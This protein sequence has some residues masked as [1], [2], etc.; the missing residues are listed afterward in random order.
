MDGVE[1]G[2]DGSEPNLEDDCK[3]QEHTRCE[4]ILHYRDECGVVGAF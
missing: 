3:G 4:F 1:K 2:A